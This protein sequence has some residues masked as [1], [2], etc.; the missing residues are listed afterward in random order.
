MQKSGYTIFSA[1]IRAVGISL[2]RKN[3]TIPKQRIA[4][5]GEPERKAT[6]TWLCEFAPRYRAVITL[7]E[8]CCSEIVLVEAEDIR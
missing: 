4:F 2:F 7:Q 5:N 1:V 6:Q 3:A 8:A